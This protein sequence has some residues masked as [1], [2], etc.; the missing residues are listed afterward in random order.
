MRCP[1]CS[2]TSFDHLVTCEKC[3]RDLTEIVNQL[4]GTSL[5]VESPSFLGP[6]LEAKVAEE[7]NA[8][9]GAT[10]DGDLGLAQEAD[11]SQPADTGTEDIF[12]AEEAAPDREP[13]QAKESP[14]PAPAQADEVELK[15][16]MEGAAEEAAEEI[17]LETEPA[18]G[19]EVMPPVAESSAPAAEG[20]PPVAEATAEQSETTGLNFEGLDLSDLSPAED[21]EMEGGESGVKEESPLDLWSLDTS[22][23]D[24][25]ADLFDDLLPSDKTPKEA[26]AADDEPAEEEEEGGDSAAAA[27]EQTEKDGS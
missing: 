6:A 23:D 16:Q 4:H 14:P 18:G 9:T 19:D 10:E 12:A 22:G 17:S 11:L 5:K 21:M 20:S 1:K 25:L 15:L 3:G 2:F 13:E 27:D 24:D 7:A 26:T 8:V